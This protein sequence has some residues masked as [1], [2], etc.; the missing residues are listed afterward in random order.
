MT[1]KDSFDFELIA[2]KSQQIDTHINTMELYLST[3]DAD[4]ELLKAFC[5]KRKSAFTTGFFSYLVFFDS[6]DKAV[7]PKTP[8]TS[9]Y[10]A[11]SDVSVHITALYVY[12]AV[13]GYSILTTYEKNKWD[14]VP[15]E[16]VI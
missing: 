2:S 9:E 7:F 10:G 6:K 12:N 13:N 15:Q 11:E 4:L 5:K 14:S 16:H 3:A 1:D 8:F